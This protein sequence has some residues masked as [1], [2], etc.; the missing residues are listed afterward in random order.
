M[1][2]VRRIHRVVI[3]TDDPSA[4]GAALSRALGL[5]V[6]EPFRMYGTFASMLLDAGTAFVEVARLGPP[7][8]RPTG[9]AR[10]F[11]IAFEPP[12][13]DEAI[14]ELDARGI[15]HGAPAHHP[16]A[17]ELRRWTN[18]L[19]DDMVPGALIFLCDYAPAS[20]PRLL[21]DG[22]GRDRARLDEIVIHVRDIERAAARWQRLLAPTEQRLPGEWRAGNGPSLRVIAGESDS[23][24]SLTFVAASTTG[25]SAGRRE[26]TPVTDA[27]RD[28][29]VPPAALGGLEIRVRTAHS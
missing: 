14:R 3:E 21:D 15:A 13:L 1:H 2:V 11:G 28:L 23:I 29:I 16:H 9:R 10:L 5:R 4:I 18:V 12:S 26:R 25:A 24:A 7:V 17:G 19:I 6:V 20:A 8:E 22:G 27:A